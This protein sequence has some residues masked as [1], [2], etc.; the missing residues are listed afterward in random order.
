M[1]FRAWSLLGAMLAALLFSAPPP[2]TAQ[3]PDRF[4]ALVFSK[5]TGFR[6]ESAIAAG[7]TALQQMGVDEDFAVTVSEDAGLFT[8]AGLR[9]F[10]VVVFLNTDG[11]GILSA[12]QRTAFERWTQRGGGIV[13]IHA[14][15]NADR[16]WAWKGDM[17]GGAWFLNHP[18]GEAQFQ[19]ATVNRV[20]DTHPSTVDVPES[21][22]R[23][24]EWYNFTAE[25]RD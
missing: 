19:N 4:D 20:D 8:D 10:E 9:D 17:M 18:A 2:A 23:E 5:T 3:E 25:P 21:W 14:D 6:H 7:K 1:G 15:A 24:D 11:E 12:A 13:S 22:V 16:N